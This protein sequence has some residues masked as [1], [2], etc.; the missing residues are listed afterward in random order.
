MG[1]LL[2]GS[3][4]SRWREDQ[5]CRSWVGWGGGGHVQTGCFLCRLCHD[6]SV[7]EGDRVA[8]IY[9]GLICFLTVG[10]GG[11]GCE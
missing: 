8:C 11:R 10:G 9:K 6:A 3:F 5:T 1:Y 2:C 7:T 4:F